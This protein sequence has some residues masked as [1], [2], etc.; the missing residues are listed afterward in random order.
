[1]PAQIEETV[2][3]SFRL[4][5]ED[6]RDLDAILRARCKEIDPDLGLEYDV[7]RR[8]GLRYSTADVED[9]VKERNGSETRLVSV[10]IRSEMPDLLRLKVSFTDKL[11]ISIEGQ[12]RARVVL[13]AS[14]IRNLARER[15]ARPRRPFGGRHIAAA[16]V[17]AIVT[18]LAGIL[19]MFGYLAIQSAAEG[20][21]N[22]LFDKQNAAYLAAERSATVAAEKASLAAVKT[23][24]KSDSVSAKLDFLVSE[25][26]R[27]GVSDVA[28][29]GAPQIPDS[30]VPPW[31]L[32]PSVFI[33]PFVAWGAAYAALRF[34]WPESESVFLVGHEIARLS[35]RQR[36]REHIVWGI[37][38]ALALG[39]ISSII[40]SRIP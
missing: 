28:I 17:L 19:Y 14:D 9:I 15:M 16:S 8:D 22:A 36:R 27:R 12:D 13:M 32:F 29:S 40:A 25:D 1:M 33:S 3:D 37:G 38:V 30:L 26:V 35:A 21:Q 11:R 4:A 23:L 18:F 34:L 24:L 20:R 39:V 31:Y 2:L 6:L 10:M 7:R 5:V